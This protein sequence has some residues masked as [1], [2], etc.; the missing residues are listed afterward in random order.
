MAGGSRNFKTV[1]GRRNIRNEK[2]SAEKLTF[3]IL[4][5]E[6]MADDDGGNDE[7]VVKNGAFFIN[8]TK[9]KNQISQNE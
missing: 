7:K 5:V 3:S 4:D 6:K 1:I 8:L 2:F 9:L